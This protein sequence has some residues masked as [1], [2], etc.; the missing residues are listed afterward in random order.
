MFRT[1]RFARRAQLALTWAQEGR[2]P[3]AER[4]AAQAERAAARQLRR[5]R[6]A[7]QSADVRAAEIEAESRRFPAPW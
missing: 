4:D 2:L 6:A 7:D 5:E 3:A 1:P